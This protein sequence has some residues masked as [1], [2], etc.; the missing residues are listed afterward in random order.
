MTGTAEARR[1][2]VVIGGGARGL[3]FTE[4]LTHEVGASVAAIVEPHLPSHAFVHRRLDAA[5]ITGVEVLSD[6]TTALDAYPADQVDGVFVMTPEW[7]HAAIFREVTARGYH[8]FLEKPIATTVEDALEIRRIAE[9]Y[10]QVIQLG[11]VLRYS[12]FYRTVKAW[13]D[14][15]PLGR[16][17]M[18]Q[19]N[20]RLT[21]AHG[22]KFKR[23]WHRLVEY[24]GGYINEKCSHDL[25][26]MCWFKEAEA[27]PVRVVSMGNRGFARDGVGQTE[28]ATC[29]RTDCLYRDDPTTYDKYVDGQ[30]LLDH[31]GAGVGRCIYGNDSDINDNQTVLIQFSDGSHGVFSSIAMS[32]IHGRDL[33]IHCEYGVIWGD[34]EAGTVH[35]MDYRTGQTETVE[36]TGMNMHGGGDTQVVREFVECIAEGT[37]PV[38]RVADG[39][40]ATVIALTADASI[41]RREVLDL[42]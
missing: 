22:M 36:L 2:F 38:A 21:V 24:T 5:G 23:S 14:G 42:P 27:T 25:D 18:I 9:S 8:I 16:I 10:P 1:R 7:T 30:V 15:S 13:L 20:E 3:F 11:F 19:M 33:A 41:A 37:Q 32:G 39:V 31:T 35:R 17:V 34:L 29:P 4:I 12:A 28:C 40:R 26:L 6:L